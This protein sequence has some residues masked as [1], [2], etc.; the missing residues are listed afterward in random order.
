MFDFLRD[1]GRS[2][3][4]KRHETVSAYLDGR[5]SDAERRRF[6]AELAADVRLREELDQ[7]RVVR[8]QLEAMPA[9]RVPRSYVLDPARYGKP[10]P[11]PVQQ[12]YP[13]LRGA[14]ALTALVFALVLGLNVVQFGF[15]GSAAPAAEIA[16]FESVSEEAMPAAAPLAEQS[17]DQAYEESAPAAALSA[18]VEAEAAQN[19]AE[20][21]VQADAAPAGSAP[22]ERAMP[23][24]A[25]A[26]KEGADAA[27]LAAAPAAAPESI[28]SAAAEGAELP[29]SGSVTGYGLSPMGMIA[30]ALGLATLALAALTLFLR[31]RL[32][33]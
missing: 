9:R 1:V 25:A 18:P 20:A 24:E 13:V 4:E 5:L 6:E 14:T 31:R 16:V 22:T 27:E 2:A 17:A 23:T 10:K 12:L 26:T 11:Q 7:L 32:P 30:I 21:A 33:F 19:A 8:L 3:E 28:E 29:A 15:G